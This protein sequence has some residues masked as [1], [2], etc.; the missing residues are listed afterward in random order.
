MLREA[1]RERVHVREEKC[2]DPQT[3]GPF[4]T[5]R[6]ILAVGGAAREL[7]LLGACLKARDARARAQVDRG[8]LLEAENLAVELEHLLGGSL[9]ASEHVHRWLPEQGSR[10]LEQ[11]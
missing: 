5:A 11:R 4:D 3:G 9:E 10:R 8:E 2:D 6:L 1:A 7:E